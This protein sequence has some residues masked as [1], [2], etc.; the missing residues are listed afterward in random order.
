MQ[1]LIT[2]ASSGMGREMAVYLGKMGWDLILVARRSDKLE[3]LKEELPKNISVSLITM[4]ISVAENAKSLYEQVKDRSIDMLINN[5]GFGINGEF[6]SNV[7]FSVV[8]P[9]NIIIPDS[10]LGSSKSC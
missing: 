10:T 4:D 7:G 8:A 5:A 3:T 1:V 2:G 9:I 6:I